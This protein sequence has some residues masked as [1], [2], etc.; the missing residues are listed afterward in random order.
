MK[1]KAKLV[2]SAGAAVVACAAMVA[3]GSDDGSPL[4]DGSGAG[5]GGSG[6]SGGTSSDPGINLGSSGDSGLPGAGGVDQPGAAGAGC[7]STKVAADPPIVNVLLVV[8][9]SFS[10]TGTPT[11]F[12]TDK[13]SA[14]R[15]ALAATFEQTQDRVSYGLDLYPF[16]GETGKAVSDTCEMPKGDAVVVPVQ[17]GAK[18]APLILAALDDNPPD[19]DTP[20]AA[21]LARALNYY[22]KGAGKTLK[23]DKFVLLATDGGPNCDAKATCD[24][25]TCTVNMDGKCPLAPA[26]CC[27]VS[28][29]ATSC[30]DEDGSVAGVKALAAAGIKTFVVGIPGTE[31]YADTLNALAAE[32]GVDN[33]DAPPDYFAVSAKSGA[34]GLTNTLT[35]I[36]AGLITSCRLVLEETPPAPNDVYVVI[37][38]VEIERGGADGWVYDNAVSPPAIV[39]QGATCDALERDGAEYINVT[40][41]CPDF[42][43]PVK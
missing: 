27:D 19:G 35:K 4:L 12:T 17:A 30:L 43:P 21:A 15:G 14:L 20:T 22:T 28:G 16:S 24:A 40:Y 26:S 3:C 11:G 41:G 8:D 36:T 5:S 13:W 34:V 29:G 18:A 38:G 9:K 6:S 10:M 2:A 37:D 32:S 39:I 33:P 7:G 25:A 23:G 1:L 42:R 31:A